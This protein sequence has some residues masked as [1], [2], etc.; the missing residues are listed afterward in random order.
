MT[1]TSPTIELTDPL[2]QDLLAAFDALNGLHAGFR[3]AHAKGAMV[4]GTF[5]P[6]AAA[7]ELTRAPHI[8]RPSTRV[9]VRFSDFAGVPTIADNDPNGGGPRGMATRFYL[10]EHEHT[11][12]IAHSTDGFPAR[13]GEE[14][15]GF[16]RAAKAS[17]PDTPH[18]TPIEQ[19]LGAH[20]AALAFV[21]TPK[22]I[23]TSFARESFFGRSPLRFTSAAGES[24]FGRYRVRPAAGAE[25]LSPEAA[26]AKSANFLMDELADRLSR[27]PIEFR[28]TVQLAGA[29]DPIDDATA[30]WPS[31][32]PEI[33]FGT[34][35][36]TKLEDHNEPELHKIIFDP[37]PRVDGIEA[38]NDPLLDVRATLYLLSGRRRRAAT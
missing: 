18:P 27:S 16:L 31:D 10:G 19:F 1:S 14:F 23:P 28:I 7:K 20:P 15:L 6:A 22:P 21:M 3:P 37:I 26:A 13:T 5:T 34:L 8:D 11:D 17:G 12:I 2:I 38:S 29:G 24:K 33:D 9:I 4:S 25:Y 32:R 30:Q 35:S 36:L